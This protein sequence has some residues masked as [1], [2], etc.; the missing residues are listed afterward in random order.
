METSVRLDGRTLVKLDARPLHV[1]DGLLLGELTMVLAYP[2]FWSIHRAFPGVNGP[3]FLNVLTD[4]DAEA[5]I[6]TL[7][8]VV[9]LAIVGCIA[10]VIA[11]DIRRDR[12]RVDFGWFVVISSLFAMMFDEGLS[13]HERLID[14]LRA[15]LSLSAGGPLRFAWVIVGIPFALGLALLL[16]PFVR[17][18]DPSVRRS[19]NLGVAIFLFGA[20]GLEM[21]GGK[22]QGTLGVDSFWY[23]C[24]VMAEEGCE[25][26]GI[27]LIGLGLVKELRRHPRALDRLITAS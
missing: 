20:I 9:Q 27:S 23:I 6:P 7:L 19:L 5:S 11:V 26:F 25:M 2:V 10:S 13:F 22:I 8:S 3:G 16:R 14:P 17:S 1:W 4:L 15:A 12:N 21:V 18:L 24:E